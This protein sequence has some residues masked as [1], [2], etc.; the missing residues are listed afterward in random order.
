MKLKRQAEDFQVEE[1]PIVRGGD[2]GRFTFYRLSKRGLGT[3]EAIEAICRRWNIAGGRL[4]Y[5][6]L[7]DRHAVTVQYLTILDGPPREMHQTHFDL[8]PLG[9]LAH[10]Y[11]PAH[12]R[13]NRFVVVLRD[14][15]SRAVERATRG[16]G[17]AASR[18]PAQLF[19]RPAV[20]LGRVR[21]RVHR[22]GLAGRRPRAGPPA[23]D[24]R[25]ERLGPPGD[26][27]REGNPPRAL[28]ALARGEGP[29]RPLAR[30]EPGHLPGG[31]PDRLPGRLRPGPPRAAVA[32]LLGLPEP[33]LEPL[34]GTP[35]RAD[36]PTGSAHPRSTSSWP[37]C[38]SIAASTP[39]RPRPW[40]AGESP[41][42]PPGPPC[43]KA[44]RATW[45]SR[46]WASSA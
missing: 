5:G 17:G 16:A 12:F 2:R 43:P 35:D 20:R 37:R 44:P 34:A 29:P 21:R 32:L 4:N 10:P 26:E 23:G 7:K 27:G 46:S 1:L 13:G 45:P 31:P 3:L 15:T 33:P 25:A 19:R 40:P 30:A 36:H 8:E 24:R 42:P 39:S 11:G 14:L 22:P 38:R 6:G 28:G 9:R 18:R 41:C